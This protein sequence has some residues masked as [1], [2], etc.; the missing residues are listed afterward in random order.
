MG[1][2]AI[3]RL[4]VAVVTLCLSAGVAKAMNTTEPSGAGV[5]ES[6]MGG[7]SIANPVTSAIA[8]DNPAGMAYVGSR[9][10]FGFQLFNGKAESSFANPSNTQSFVSIGPIPSG[11]VN[12]D[13]TDRWSAG[14]SISS[15]GG[16]AN[17]H[18]PALPIPGAPP[19]QSKAIFANFWP[20]VTY[21]VTPNLAVG[22]SAIIGIQKFEAQGL[23]GA[24]PDGSIAVL[25]THGMS[26]TYGYGGAVGAIWKV[27]PYVTVGASYSSK[28]RFSR[29]NGY[30]DDLFSSGGG[31]LDEPARFGVGVAFHI[32]PDLTLATDLVRIQWTN[33]D[34]LADPKTFGLHNQTVLRIG[35]SWDV[36]NAI[37]LRI[38]GNHSTNAMDSNHTLA[39]YYVPLI[40]TD[41][42]SGGVT[43]HATKKVDLSAGFEYNF[44]KTLVG[45]GPS[46][47]TNLHARYSLFMLNFSNRF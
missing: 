37:T 22:L 47:G 39:N 14:V 24:A 42:V 18:Y 35:A 13:L 1:K 11:G 33:V 43:W 34:V 40:L 2:I 10:D 46:T 15:T 45:T 28:I 20:T 5:V 17:Y 16:G 27:N 32:T 23:L 41:S 44:P 7:A 26:T 9:F 6:M 8:A 3:K 12:F 25:P 19:A 36:N 31:H 30:E 38:G 21:K 29:A 4:L